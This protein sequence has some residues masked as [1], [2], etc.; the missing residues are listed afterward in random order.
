[1]TKRPP[2]A[3]ETEGGGGGAGRPSAAAPS[4]AGPPEAGPLSLVSLDVWPDSALIARRPQ[5]DRAH[6]HKLNCKSIKLGRLYERPAREAPS[7]ILSAATCLCSGRACAGALSGHP[8]VRA[9]TPDVRSHEARDSFSLKR[10]RRKRPVSKQSKRA[11]CKD[12]ETARRRESETA[13]ARERARPKKW[14]AKRWP[15]ARVAWRKFRSICQADRSRK[16]F[17][18]EIEPLMAGGA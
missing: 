6:L 14:P 13:K 12:D 10:R 16:S 8:K 9:R 3:P 15:D 17:G 2:R 18:T 1:M 11:A 4:A 5:D 7:V